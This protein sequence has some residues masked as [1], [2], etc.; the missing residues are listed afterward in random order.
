[1]SSRRTPV[2][3]IVNLI[4]CSILAMT[5]LVAAIAF[6]STDTAHEAAIGSFESISMDS[7]WRLSVGEESRE[8][9]LPY[10]CD[11]EKGELVT[12]KNT[13]P[14]KIPDGSSLLTRTSLQDIYIYVDGELREQYATESI[15]NMSYYIPSA[16]VV[17]SLSSADAGK[18]VVIQLRMKAGGVINQVKLGA[19][20]NVWFD[21]LC[22]N[23]PVD[24]VVLMA[25]VIGCILFLYSAIVRNSV[26]RTTSSFYL[27]LLV[28]DVAIWMISESPIRQILFAK[29]SLT[30]YFAYSSV[31]LIGILACLYFDEVQHR[32]HHKTYLVAEILGTVQIIINFG[33]YLSGVMELYE[34]LRFSHIL[35]AGYLVMAIVLIVKDIRE[36]R[37]GQ[38]KVTAIGMVGL[39]VA[40]GAEIL[41]FYLAQIHHFGACICIG[42]ILLIVATLTQSRMDEIRDMRMRESRQRKSI[43]TT[44]KTIAGTIDAKDQ[45]T[46]GHSERVG[47]YAAILARAMAADYD[48]SEEDIERIHYIG[49][50]HDIGKIGVPDSV[51]NKAGRLTEEEFIL[52][53]KHVVI[54]SDIMSA[55]DENMK[56]LLDGI[57]YHHER[58]DGK[59]YP[60]GLA[61]TDIPLVARI[62]CLADCYDAMTSD[63]VYRKRLNDEAVRAEIIRCS[64]TQFDPALSEIFVALLDSGEIYPLGNAQ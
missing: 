14:E 34:S 46:G 53:K 54:G 19:G 4:V 1:M 2:D 56:D 59:G 43:V 38:Y 60:E 63:R 7:G 50:M 45:Y 29:P 32:T 21:I 9:T 57:R 15:P 6:F 11:V 26:A 64:G 12:I 25:L 8:I 23:L 35:M 62:I 28:I 22:R 58:F 52:M 10:V 27:S 37:I 49:T 33:L 31:E 47:Q 39:L 18:E 16:Y 51:L 44:I 5:L 41:T 17:T 40:S 20:N 42:L 3:Y 13:L 36:K 30:T 55:L 24:F 48:F 61:E